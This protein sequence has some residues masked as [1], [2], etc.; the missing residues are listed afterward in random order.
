MP[1]KLNGR[2]AEIAPVPTVYTCHA[3][4][5]EPASGIRKKWLPDS[6]EEGLSAE[7]HL[8]GTVRTDSFGMI[9]CQGA[10]RH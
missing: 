2:T 9:I 7:S 8:A 4:R 1:E 6:G 10:N 5:R 3:V